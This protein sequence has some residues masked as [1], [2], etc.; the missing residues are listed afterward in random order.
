MAMKKE[1]SESDGYELFDELDKEE[2]FYN[3]D[4]IGSL[5]EDDEISDEEEAFML[6]Y[7]GS[8]EE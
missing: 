7:M 8:N 3:K 6:G 5:L 1:K 4:E 2:D